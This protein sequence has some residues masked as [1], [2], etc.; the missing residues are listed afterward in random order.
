LSKHSPKSE[1][2]N[3]YNASNHHK[4]RTVAGNPANKYKSEAQKNPVDDDIENGNA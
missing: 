2:Q 4:A 3:N 1:N